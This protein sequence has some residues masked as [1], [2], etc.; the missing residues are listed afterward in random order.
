MQQNQQQQ[1]PDSLLMDSSESCSHHISNHN[2][3]SNTSNKNPITTYDLV[4]VICH[5]G[6][7]AS[8]HYTAYCLNS[9]T[10]TWYEFDDQYVT[11][12]D[13][14]Q[15]ASCEAYVLFYRKSSDEVNEQ[16]LRIVQLIER[17]LPSSDPT[18]CYYISNQ[19]INRFNTFAEPGSISN[20]DFMC[21]HQMV[22]PELMPHVR[23]MC[24]AFSFEIWQYL[25]SKY[26]GGPECTS[27]DVCRICQAEQEAAA[28]AT[29]SAMDTQS[30]VTTTSSS[31]DSHGPLVNGNSHHTVSD[32]GVSFSLH[33]LLLD[34]NPFNP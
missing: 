20:E 22:Q 30:I 14:H 13:P 26:G 24:S 9:F 27:L 5:H 2:S 1:D 21:Q 12:V 16:R 3:N 10:D 31:T 33:S 4:S 23:D 11:A 18:D 32:S 17:T 34:E 25:V 15:V 6:T 7:P 29:A 8:G 19:W 28:A